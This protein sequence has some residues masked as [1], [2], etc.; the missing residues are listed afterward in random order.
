MRFIPHEY[1]KRAIDMIM[2]LPAVGL[3]L[4]MGLGKTV[5][6]LT[7]VR[8]LITEE[9]AVSKVLVIAPKRVAEDT[10]SR[11]HAKWDH[12]QDLRISKVLGTRS[13][14]VTALS[15]DADIYVIGRD[16]V[17]WLTQQYPKTWPFDM[18]VIDELSSFKNPQ[19]K[20]FRALR[21]YIPRADRVV[22]LTGTPSPNGLMDL[23]AQIY[24]LDRG[25]RLGLTLGAYRDRYFTAGARNGYV[26]YKWL[27]VKGAQKAIE[28][29]IRDIC[30]SMSG[31]DYLSLPKRIDNVI[32]VRLSD[33]QMAQYKQMEQNQL[34]QI[35]NEDVVALS[36]AA[37]MTKLLQMANGAVYTAG[38]TV[39]MVH[40]W[41]A[42]ALA[43]IA[44]T[45]QEPILV[46]YSYRHD[47]EAIK[48]EIPEARELNGSGDIRDWNEGKIPVLLAHPASVGYG[49][50]L[51]DG[52]HI[53]V[54][55][56]LTWSLEL[57]QQANA[58]LYR[59]GQEKPVI[60]HHLIA[61]GTVDEQVMRALQHKDTSQAALLAALK[62]RRQRHD[63]D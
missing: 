53:I 21:K 63:Q 39:A 14:R 7:A 28:K 57:Y 50:N 27:P 33:S 46:F 51:Q 32:P 38:G 55:Y 17:V 3:F 9:F 25:Q 31:D 1:Q 62:E 23:W 13:Q 22:G 29:K 58:R 37:V 30:V 56:G 16:N 47:I 24:L 48:K 45:A 59:Q 49:L 44:D 2:R 35:E 54:W 11:E 40:D 41:K 43:E 61:E 20:R 26:V 4:D 10:W 19:A 18:V 5:I 6:T 8:R 12:L 15:T 52:G 60:I 36:A 34:V 42:K